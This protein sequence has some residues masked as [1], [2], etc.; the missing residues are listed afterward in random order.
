MFSR[1]GDGAGDSKAVATGFLWLYGEALF[2]ITNW[3]NVSGLNPETGGF[4]GSFSP[5]TVTVGLKV[6][7]DG[8]NGRQAYTTANMTMA[9]FGEDDRPTWLEHPSRHRV[10]CVAL[11]L[12]RSSLPERFAG[13]AINMIGFEPRYHSTV[14]DDCFVVG[15][16]MGLFGQAATPIWKRASVATEPDGD[17]N[18]QPI[19]LVDTATRQGMSGSPVIVRHDGIFMPN[20]PTLKG[21]ETIGTV[22]NFLGIYSGRLGDDPLGVQLGRVWKAKVVDEIMAAQLPGLHPHDVQFGQA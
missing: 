14:G 1:T 18:G 19:L 9:L 6:I 4:N 7:V 16:P 12:D 11:P 22:E 20:G 2:L 21:D 10:D 17:Q 15:F 13:K 8:A 5:N 3:H